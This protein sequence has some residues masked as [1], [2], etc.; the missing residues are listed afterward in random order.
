M[1]RL[2]YFYYGILC[3]GWATLRAC[4]HGQKHYIVLWL[5]YWIMY[6][7]LQAFGSLTDSLFGA[8]TLYAT[9]KLFLSVCLWFSVPYSTNYM[10]HLVGENFLS[11]LEPIVDFGCQV[12]KRLFMQ[13]LSFVFQSSIPS[14]AK[15]FAGKGD[16][17]GEP[18]VDG[19]Q[20]KLE[21][22]ELVT[23]IERD[24]AEKLRRYEAD[25]LNNMELVARQIVPGSSPG[26]VNALDT[27]DED[28][29]HNIIEY[30]NSRLESSQS[31]EGGR[32]RRTRFKTDL[33]K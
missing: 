4:S 8:R 26:Q 33:R 11:K 27:L 7:L 12:H 18:L 21:L 31:S 3:P 29:M 13:V 5:R 24:E 25:L 22:S 20:L 10:Y 16:Q 28:S 17:R 6:A 9:V 23:E 14:A 15:G 32:S 2:I 1:L 30:L 19:R